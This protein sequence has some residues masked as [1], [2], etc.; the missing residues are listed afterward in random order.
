MP[1]R[2]SATNPLTTPKSASPKTSP[3]YYIE[4]SQMA[5]VPDTFL[6]PTGQIDAEQDHHPAD[7]LIDPQRLAEEHDT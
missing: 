4:R 5:L 6:L 1:G 2:L 7:D 3:D